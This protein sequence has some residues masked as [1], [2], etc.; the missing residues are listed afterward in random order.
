MVKRGL[1]L[2]DEDG[3]RT[4]AYRF[5][6]HLHRDENSGDLI[7]LPPIIQLGAIRGY[8]FY[9]GQPKTCRKCGG[10]DHLA[11]ECENVVCRNCN[12]EEHITSECPF[13]RKCNLC[14]GEGHTFRACPQSY[15][16]K[17]KRPHQ[18]HLEEIPSQLAEVCQLLKM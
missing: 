1:D 16:N 13:P 15:A 3:I 7:H 9:P 4:G 2:K 18:Q 17:V 10:N 8:V 14:G 12:S 6:V 5:Y 11:V